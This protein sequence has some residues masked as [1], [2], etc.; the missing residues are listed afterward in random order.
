M[1]KTVS[2][3]DAVQAPDA[4]TS[5]RAVTTR[6]WPRSIT[7][8][9]QLSSRSARTQRAPVRMSAPRSAASTAVRT[10]S[11]ESSTTQS[12]YSKARPI[13]RFSALPTGWWVISMVADAGSRGREARRSYSNSHDRST[14]GCRSSEWAGMTK[15]I[16][17]TRC[18]AVRSQISRSLSAARTRNNAR[19]SSPW[20]SPWISRGEACDAP[21]PR[22]P[23][24]SRITRSPRPA[25]SRAML[26]PLRPPPMI[27][28]S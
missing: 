25:A 26:T 9:R 21:A 27:A 18:G 15:R 24:S 7:A 8:S 5:A 22:S 16:G 4:L 14:Q 12:E 10:T 1:R 20:R 17:R 11:R 3:T 13:G 28:R 23:C 2:A 19:R 6:R